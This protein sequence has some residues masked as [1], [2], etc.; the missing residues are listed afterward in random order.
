MEFNLSIPLTWL[1]L[2]ISSYI[3]IDEHMTF[4]HPYYVLCD[5]TDL[6]V[7]LRTFLIR[8]MP[9]RM[10]CRILHP[11]G[12]WNHH[13][14]IYVFGAQA[15]LITPPSM[16]EVTPTS[17]SDVVQLWQAWS[18]WQDAPFTSHV[19]SRLNKR[20]GTAIPN[21]YCMKWPLVIRG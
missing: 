11:P 14:P 9:F 5:L 8:N 17:P 6:T 1:A 12:L 7:T 2:N 4:R 3:I 20:G 16:Q 21:R 15:L 18:G 19:R 10:A 13:K